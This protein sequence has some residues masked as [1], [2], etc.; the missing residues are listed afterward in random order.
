M[1]RGNGEG[2]IYKRKDGRW[3]GAFYSEADNKRHFVYASSYKRVKAKMREKSLES[4]LMDSDNRDDPEVKYSLEDWI[5]EYLEVY[6]RNELKPSTFTGYT[7]VWRKHIKGSVIGK[8]NLPKI[9]PANIQG[10]YNQKLKAGLSV[11]SIW[12]IRNLISTALKQA[13]REGFIESNPDEYIVLP[14]KSR[15]EPSILTP[16]EIRKI[17]EEAKDDPLYPIVVTA[18][19]TGMRKGEL[20][21]LQWKNVDFK[22][23]RIFVE[24]SLGVLLHQE[25]SDGK[26]HNAYELVEPKSKKSKRFIPM[27]DTVVE[28]LRIQRARQDE[29]RRRYAEI[30]KESDFVFTEED[31]E[32]INQK[33]FMNRYHTF[34][35]KYGITDCRF[36]DLRH[37]FA[38]LM[39]QRGVDFKTLS[40]ILGHSQI[41]TSL[42]IYAHVYDSSKAIAVEDFNNLIMGKNEQPGK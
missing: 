41:S 9:R 37:S 2:T 3:C 32:I 25:G 34:L 42:D 36:H 20:M 7:T 29:N 30:Y 22:H 35:K 8:M 31:G 33:G 18:L 39:L 27:A 5:W 12:Q 38:S 40:D 24:R 11:K 17:V 10:F 19:F 6:K 23:R 21:A 28:A 16:E 14:K 26:F 1:K 4:T 15:Y 13:V